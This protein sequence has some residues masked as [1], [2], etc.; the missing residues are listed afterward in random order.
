VGLLLAACVLAGCYTPY[1]GKREHTV[2][3]IWEYVYEG[4]AVR[5]EFTADNKCI[6]YRGRRAFDKDEV[7]IRYDDN[8]EA[9]SVCDYRV[10]NSRTVLVT[11]TGRKKEKLVY[12]VLADGR[13]SVEQKHIAERVRY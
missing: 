1:Q 9:H 13:L 3:G 8:G 12:E 10:M 6:M 2:V 11:K 5:R 4:L 7:R